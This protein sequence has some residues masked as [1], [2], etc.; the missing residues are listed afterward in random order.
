MMVEKLGGVQLR[1][2][3]RIRLVCLVMSGAVFPA[4]ADDWLRLPNLTYASDAQLGAINRTGFILSPDL[5]INDEVKLGGNGGA[6]LEDPSGFAIGARAGYDYQ[7]GNVLLGFITDGYYSFADG[8]GR[9]AGSGTL[10]SE[11]R[12]YGTVRGRLGYG[13]GRFLP[14]V[15]GGYAYGDLK[16][17]NDASG[18]S[19]SAT[20]SGWTYGGGLEFVWNKD[21]TL[22]GGYRRIDFDDRTFAALPVGQNTLSPEIDVID[23]GWVRRF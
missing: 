12:Y 18:L 17:S 6:L 7:V 22:Y 20:L 14:Y 23:I 11:L 5:S 16:V 15:T 3:G 9:G 10:K 1:K 13:I 4:Q 2:I 21:I 19:S 8:N